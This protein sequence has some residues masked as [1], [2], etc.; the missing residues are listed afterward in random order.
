MNYLSQLVRF[1]ILY[2]LSNS[3][4][5]KSLLLSIIID[6]CNTNSQ[7]SN[8][9]NIYLNNPNFK[10][11]TNLDN[12]TINSYPY[13]KI[14][15]DIND[16]NTY[17]ENN[18]CITN[19]I[20]KYETKI[21]NINNN[22]NNNNINSST[23]T[24]N[25]N[26]FYES[27]DIYI[28]NKN[29]I[30]KA[31][32]NNHTHNPIN[33]SPINISNDI[34]NN[35]KSNK[36]NYSNN[37]SN[38]NKN[39]IDNYIHNPISNNTIDTSTDI[40]SI[41]SNKL[42]YSSDIITDNKNIIDNHNDNPISNSTIDISNDTNSI[43]TNKLNYSNDISND[44]KNIIDNHPDNPISTSTI[45]IS[46]DINSDKYNKLNYSN[47]IITDNKNIID[48][49]TDNPISTSI[50]DISTDTNSSNPN[51][52]NLSNNPQ[53]SK[54]HKNESFTNTSINHKNES[55]ESISILKSDKIS[56]KKINNHNPN[57][58]NRDLIN[59]D[60]NDTDN[61]TNSDTDNK[62]IKPIDNNNSIVNNK[63]INKSEK[64]AINSNI[65]NKY[66][67]TSSIKQLKE[68]S[69]I[70]VSKV[71]NINS[72]NSLSMNL[73]KSPINIC[74]IPFL[75]GRC[76]VN[77]S[78]NGS[79]D[80]SYPINDIIINS[81][82]I[83]IKENYLLADNFMGVSSALFYFEG[84]LKTNFYTLEPINSSKKIINSSYKDNIIYT[85]FTICK[86]LNIGYLL[87]NEH[88]LLK[89]LDIDII[90]LTYETSKELIKVNSF[91][92]NSNSYNNCGITISLDYNLN[93]YTK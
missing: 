13:N 37:I 1:L 26:I 47:D 9:S 3:N 75:I 21:N 46:T 11:T 65:K 84:Y 48:N 85:P 83:V 29:N 58:D 79:L 63:V 78:F 38:D 87:E 25:K 32:N 22:N 18:N 68:S 70:K 10:F 30:T 59:T 73:P 92:K 90:D 57:K 8:D 27:T 23:F 67:I 2:T 39:I 17:L 34:N 61:Y 41:N 12:K 42:N 7:Q 60:T 62:F 56:N 82:T 4:F 31:P 14:S 51:K 43:N 55:N 28:N 69:I 33:T 88:Y 66:I 20:N 53:I 35:N 36:L 19:I 16:I 77:D 5:Q 80:F 52:L 93:I 49:H 89:N 44:N 40:N 24:S 6:L 50:I 74:K 81:N 71:K 64:K 54:N 86:Y 45:N 72:K 91:N 76:T 15:K